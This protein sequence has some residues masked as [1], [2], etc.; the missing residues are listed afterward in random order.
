MMDE[1]ADVVLPDWFERQDVLARLAN[2]VVVK[3]RDTRI[4]CPRRSLVAI[5][6]IPRACVARKPKYIE[7][8]ILHHR[9]LWHRHIVLFRELTLTETHL[10][11]VMDCI[12]GGT[13]HKLVS[14]RRYGHWARRGFHRIVCL[15]AW[16]GCSGMVEGGARLAK[17]RGTTEGPAA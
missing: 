11:I 17:R 2:G 9:K 10:C 16:W 4:D 3:A 15:L 6:C 1:G 12:G 14:E 7:R 8:E 5:K 13:L